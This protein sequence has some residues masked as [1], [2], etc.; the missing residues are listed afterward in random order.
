MK[1]ILYTEKKGIIRNFSIILSEFP[2]RYGVLIHGYALIGKRKEEEWLSCD[3]ILRQYS[4][5]EAKA[6]RLYQAFVEEGLM[7]ILKISDKCA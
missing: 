7:Q 3:W 4:Q 6:R 1:E 2:P 5:D